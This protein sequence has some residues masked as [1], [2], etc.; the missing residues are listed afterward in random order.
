MKIE[1]VVATRLSVPMARPMR[2]AIHATDRTENVLVEIES[3]GLVGQGCTLAFS[4]GQSDAVGAMARDLGQTL[5]G[6]DVFDLGALWGGL[7]MR[8]NLTGQSGVGML[9]LSAIDTALWDLLSQRAGLPLSVMLGRVHQRLPVYAQGG[10]LSYSVEQLVD[11]ALLYRSRGFRHYKMR[12][13]SPD[14][15]TDVTRVEA[16]L[17]AA[18]PDF[19]LMLDANQ[20]WPRHVAMQA[21]AAIDDL[22]LFWLEEPVDVH[23]LVGSAEIAG[24]MRTPISSGETVFGV[25]GFAEMIERRAADILMPDLQH[26]GGP[27]GF[28]RV[29]A[30]AEAAHLPVSGH[31]F[32][33]VSI[34]LLAACPN[35][36]VVEYMPGWWEE[37]FEG[38]PKISEGW[39]EPG[40]SPGLGFRV[41]AETKARFKA[42]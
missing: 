26:C 16:V 36:L 19:H 13:G 17:A 24:A 3:D 6:S 41:T 39:I 20:G 30:L 9:A 18:G 4:A 8:L 40:S 33:E 32:T 12:V 42:D 23:D 1:R 22:G 15:R 35:A 34:H 2:T 28:M 21:A 11:E 31:L 38:A 27:T 5:V 25:A 7:W 10:W 37:L 29:A 14:W